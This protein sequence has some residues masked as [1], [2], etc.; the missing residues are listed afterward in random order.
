MDHG[1]RLLDDLTA[2]TFA[3]CDLGDSSVVLD[4]DGKPHKLSREHKP[5]DPKEARRIQQHGGRLIKHVRR[6]LL[7]WL[8]CGIMHHMLDS[9]PAV[10]RL[11]WC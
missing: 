6:G 11:R 8:Q 2:S 9:G 3:I 4:R 5:E 1:K 7:W 10:L